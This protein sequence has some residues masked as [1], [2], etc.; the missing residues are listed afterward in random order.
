V[1]NF[2]LP[3]RSSVL[4]AVQPFIDATPPNESI[5]MV[6]GP[7]K[8]GY[9]IVNYEYAI[10]KADQPSETVARDLRGFLHWAITTGTSPSTYLSAVGF[11]PLP[12]PVR[13]LAE[14]QI[15]RIR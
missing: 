14:Q 1:G 3:S 13:Q 11:Q 2:E 12:D 6:N 9:P 4:G 7:A 8:Y 5:S 10:V 15:A